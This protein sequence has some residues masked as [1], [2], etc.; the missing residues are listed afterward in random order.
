MTRSV[1]RG[2][3]LPVA[4][5]ITIPV[6]HITRIS[7]DAI[8]SAPNWWITRQPWT[9][10]RGIGY[11]MLIDRSMRA[12]ITQKIYLRIEMSKLEEEKRGGIR[13]QEVYIYIFLNLNI[14]FLFSII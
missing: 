6:I 8:C 9:G 11:L 4:F 14:K 3:R 10:R 13:A 12:E 5:L 2:S 1:R 7:T